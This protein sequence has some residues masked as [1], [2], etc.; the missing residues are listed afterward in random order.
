M[1]A[2]PPALEV[3]PI[4]PRPLLQASAAPRGLVS[5]LPHSVPLARAGDAGTGVRG[6]G[7]ETRR[8][9][10]PLARLAACWA[11]PATARL[12][13]PA[14]PPPAWHDAPGGRGLERRAAWGTMSRGTAWAVRAAR[15]WGG[16]R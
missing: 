16:E 8:G 10:R 14:V 11:P 2:R 15:R 7:L 3:S 6:R 12:C 9:R 13:G 5:L 1:P 4:H